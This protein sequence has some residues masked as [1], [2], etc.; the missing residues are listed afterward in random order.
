MT[1]RRVIYRGGIEAETTAGGPRLITADKVFDS[2]QALAALLPDA[3]P[4]L[5][6]TSSPPEL[7]L[8]ANVQT[9]RALEIENSELMTT[10][11]LN[12]R[13]LYDIR[14]LNYHLGALTYHCKRL[15]LEYAQLCQSA[16]RV[17]RIPG[18]DVGDRVI[19]GGADEAYYEFDA[20]VTVARRIYDVLRFPLWKFFNSRHPL[21]AP[22]FE[23]VLSRTD[24][25]PSHLRSAL[26]RSW[27]NYG[28]KA[29]EYRDSVVHFVPVEFGLG[30]ADMSRLPCGAWQAMVRIPDN[31]GDRSR[32]KF[33]YALN[34]DALAFCHELASEI[35]G[36]VTLVAGEI[37]SVSTREDS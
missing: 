25:M 4:V 3:R 18:A 35:A 24:R 30:S 37:I 23:Q 16:A 17:S 8:L 33:T 11:G 1:V 22:E 20:C 7:W 14:N 21:N 36:L 15:G 34:L 13:N 2:P 6:Q 27:T 28:L 32:S 5:L 19:Q 31:P 29:R 26:E 9:G 12:G 10:Q